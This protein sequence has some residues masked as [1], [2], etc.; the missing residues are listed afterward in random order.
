MDNCYYFLKYNPYTPI[1]S[2][3]IQRRDISLEAKGL[4]MWIS[5]MPNDFKFKENF[6]YEHFGE[7]GIIINRTRLVR[8][9][10]KELVEKNF[11]KRIRIAIASGGNRT[12]WYFDHRGI[13]P[14]ELAKSIQNYFG[15]NS[16][17]GVIKDL[18][19][20]MNIKIV[21]NGEYQP[22]NEKVVFLHKEEN[23]GEMEGGNKIEEP[24]WFWDFIARSQ[25]V[26]NVKT[27][28]RKI[29]NLNSRGKYEEFMMWKKR[30]DEFMIKCFGDKDPNLISSPRQLLVNKYYAEII[31]IAASANNGKPIITLGGKLEFP[32]SV[33]LTDATDEAVK[34]Y[35]KT[36][37][38][39]RNQ[40]N[41]GENQ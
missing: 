18:Y 19:P 17:V 41:T 9:A 30:H 4:G 33:F 39:S 15:L 40:K 34:D 12:I 31:S 35:F 14:N 27:F 13:I 28:V 20:H 29:K 26:A 23:T 24:E 16:A 7:N 8:T 5:S 3:F 38:N 2:D 11:L 22:Y 32:L 36:Y 21:D 10:M 37:K 1:P 25:K 6:F